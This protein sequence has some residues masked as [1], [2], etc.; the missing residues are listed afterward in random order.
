MPTQTAT[1][2]AENFEE[3][4]KENFTWIYKVLRALMTK[5]FCRFLNAP[6]LNLKN[7]VMGLTNLAQKTLIM[8]WLLIALKKCQLRPPLP[9]QKILKRDRKR[10]SL[11]STKCWE[12]LWPK[13]LW[14]FKCSTYIWI[15]IFLAQHGCHFQIDFTLI[16]RVLKLGLF[17]KHR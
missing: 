10:T 3:R 8:Y 17:E 2:S 11:E 9:R 15:W 6:Y 1:S 4:S 7:W 16:H 13:N 12:P 14:I 5:T